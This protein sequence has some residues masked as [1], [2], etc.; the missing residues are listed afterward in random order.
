MRLQLLSDL[1]LETEAFDPEPAPGAELLVLAGDI[2]SALGRRSRAFAAGRSRSCSSPATT[3]ST[4]ASSTTPGRRAARALRER[5]ASRML[6]RESLVVSDAEGAR[7]RFVGTTRWCDFDLFGAAG[8]AKAMRAGSYFMRPDA[9][10]AAAGG[11]ST[12]RRCAP[13]RWP[14]APGSRPS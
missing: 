11:R 1:H 6:E 3:S 10:D 5:S 7:V 2:D 13:R 9:G 4:A 8:R 14:A 12:P